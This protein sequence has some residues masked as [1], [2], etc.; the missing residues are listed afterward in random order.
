M[1]KTK[2]MMIATT[3]FVLAA[4]MSAQ[5][6]APQ[7]PAPPEQS[8]QTR[9]MQP[10]NVRIE[11]TITDQRTEVQTPPKTVTLLVEDRQS[12]RIR[13]G[14]SPFVLN[15]D[16]RPEIVREGRVRVLLG[17]E[18]TPQDTDKGPPMMSISETVAA[19]LDDG[20]SLVVSQSA[21]PASD[22][23]VRVELKATIV[24]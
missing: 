19:L 6:A 3:T 2:L 20:K 21:D 23:K 11:L 17:L 12:S 15:V 1:L 7:K 8:N 14:R 5:P 4:A 13:T 24:R 9:A 16:V 18:Y 22:R 10:T